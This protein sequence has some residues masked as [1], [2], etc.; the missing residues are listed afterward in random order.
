MI[1]LPWLR[2]DDPQGLGFRLRAIAFVPFALAGAIVMRFAT[3]SLR[4]RPRELSAIVVAAA[5][6]FTAHAIRPSDELVPGEILT[7]P[8]LVTSALALDGLVPDGDTVIIPERHIVFMVAWYAGV[9][10][11]LRPGAIPAA[12]RAGA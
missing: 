7:H 3:C 6:A 1:A 10:V 4:A 2:V 5:I 12:H 8:A 11:A 9:H